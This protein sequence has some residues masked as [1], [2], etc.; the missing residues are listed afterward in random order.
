MNRAQ[1]GALLQDLR[2]ADR[3]IQ[4]VAAIL[5]IVQPDI[6]LLNEF[7]FDATY[8][9]AKVFRQ[10]YL[11]NDI[12]ALPVLNLPYQFS[13][14]VNTGVPSG[15][16]LNRNGATTDAA[17]AFGFGQF[18]GQYGMLLLS[19]F[20]IKT[21]S[22]RTF[23]KLKW[24]ATPDALQPRDPSS[25]EEWY[26]PAVWQQLRLSSKSHWDVPVQIGEQHVHILASHPTPPAFDGAEDRNGCRNHDE[27]RFWT[28]YISPERGDWIVDDFGRRGELPGDADFVILGDLNSDPFDGGSRPAAI[29][30]LLQHA[31]IRSTPVPAS[32]G[33]RQAS[34]LQEGQNTQHDGPPQQDTA[35]FK[36]RS[37]GNLRV[38]Y[39][40]PSVRFTVLKAGIFWPTPEQPEA[41][42]LSASDHR[43]V[44]LDLHL[45]PKP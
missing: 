16:D 32:D 15:F 34:R 14:P 12:D 40:L 42:Y 21:E 31:R 30:N 43:L 9:A 20:P 27:I 1:P 22:V 41:E 26:E 10:Q 25:G 2:H 45:P 33:G 23:R 7:D 35:D 39:V 19:R 11:M 37:V 44:W 5:R 24:S 13:A 29:R 8:A 3:R 6:V 4:Q 38:D 17:D 18:P 36:D 28:D